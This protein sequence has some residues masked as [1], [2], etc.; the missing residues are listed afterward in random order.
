MAVL[1]LLKLSEDVFDFVRVEAWSR[2]HIAKEIGIDGVPTEED[3]VRGDTPVADRLP[4][5]SF[6]DCTN[7]PWNT[8]LTADSE[9]ANTAGCLMRRSAEMA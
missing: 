6:P 7:H 3:E 1:V 2:E 8:S 9:I 4:N 5:D